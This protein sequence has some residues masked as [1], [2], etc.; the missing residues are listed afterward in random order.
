MHP[1]SPKDFLFEQ[2]VV[3]ALQ[4]AF[5]LVIE[6]KPENAQ[7]RMAEVLVTFNA[8]LKVQQARM[9]DTGGRF[10]LCA[11]RIRGGG[12]DLLP[13]FLTFDQVGTGVNQYSVAA[14]LVAAQHYWLAKRGS[15]SSERSLQTDALSLV[16]AGN[17]H[18]RERLGK[19]FQKSQGVYYSPELVKLRL[20]FTS[21]EE[22]LEECARLVQ[23]IDGLGPGIL[24]KLQRSATAV[25]GNG[26]VD[27]N[28]CAPARL[29]IE[30]QE[31]VRNQH[32]GTCT[33]DI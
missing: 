1:T 32:M 18:V 26:V 7:A 17:G 13:I 14:A 5:R 11:T 25:Y 10:S 24:A 6:E 31:E 20:G 16:V 19:Y 27:E 23:F 21:Q 12:P 2:G 29:V 33:S 22:L 15:V 4:L 9:A 8:E 30:K 3:D 28:L